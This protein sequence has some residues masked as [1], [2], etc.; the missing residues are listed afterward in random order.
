[1]DFIAFKWLTGGMA[2]LDSPSDSDL[3]SSSFKYH[4]VQKKHADQL[5]DF[6]VKTGHVLL[7]PIQ[8]VNR[9]QQVHHHCVAVSQ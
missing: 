2:A 9:R 5:Q 8:G 7:R 1:M 4:P 6:H 3:R